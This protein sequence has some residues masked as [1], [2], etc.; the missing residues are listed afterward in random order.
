ML[1]YLGSVSLLSLLFLFGCDQ[2]YA[3][4]RIK[5]IVDVRGRA[6]RTSWSATAWWSA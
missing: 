5:D 1:R 3:A 6:R 4:S 2:A